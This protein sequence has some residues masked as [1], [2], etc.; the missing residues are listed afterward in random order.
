VLPQV[1]GQLAYLP[2]TLVV[3][4]FA[5]AVFGLAPRAS[6]LAWAAVAFV[7]LQVMLGQLLGLPDAVDGIS[8][9]SHLAEV[10]VDDFAV[11]PSLALVLLAGALTAVGLWGYR[12]RD[13]ATG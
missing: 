13:A 5:V 1:G 6:G 4:A 3:G 7:A 10:P 8:P 2:G 9:F 12:R 11:L